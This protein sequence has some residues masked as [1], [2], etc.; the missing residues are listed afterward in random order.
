MSF[1]KVA[2][3]EFELSVN[4]QP[5]S[6]QTKT[7]HVDFWLAIFKSYFKNNNF[8]FYAEKMETKNCILSLEQKINPLSSL[9]Q[10]ILEKIC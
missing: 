2:L 1:E 8:K 7:E 10:K 9:M 3:K 4:N 5:I 6:F